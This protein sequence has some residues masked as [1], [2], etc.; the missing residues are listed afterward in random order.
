MPFPLK[1]RKIKEQFQCFG[2]FLNRDH[3][4]TQVF[5]VNL[6]R[7]PNA[8]SFAPPQQDGERK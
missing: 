1:P 7:L 6:A 3:A 5:W 4:V 8:L 2:F